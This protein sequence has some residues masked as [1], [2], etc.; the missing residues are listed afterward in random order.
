MPSTTLRL[1]LRHNRRPFW[2]TMLC[3][4]LD[5]VI[6]RS[7]GRQNIHGTTELLCGQE[8]LERCRVKNIAVL[9]RLALSAPGTLRHHVGLAQ[10]LA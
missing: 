7:G 4:V 9:G 8:L 2:S 3:Q 5:N 1:I 10:R 6:G